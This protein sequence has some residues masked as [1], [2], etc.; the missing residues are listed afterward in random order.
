MKCAIHC[1][2]KYRPRLHK[3]ASSLADVSEILASDSMA[4]IDEVSVWN[5]EQ[6]QDL[7][8]VTC[9]VSCLHP[10]AGKGAGM[11]DVSHL[12]QRGTSLAAPGLATLS[13]A[14]RSQ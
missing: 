13:V 10:F 4:T 2:P 1:R 14:L 11:P 3:A 12:L 9:E 6:R 5:S 7:M 8:T